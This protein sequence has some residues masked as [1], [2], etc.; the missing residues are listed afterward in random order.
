MVDG[1]SLENCCTATYRGFESLRL[2]FSSLITCRQWK[3]GLYLLGWAAWPFSV[4]PE[5]ARPTAPFMT[6]DK[7]AKQPNV[8][9]IF[10]DDSG[11]ADFSFNGAVGYTTP[12]VD[13]M[14]LQGIRFTNYYSAQPISGASRSALVT[15]CYSNRIGLTGAPMTNSPFGLAEDEETIGELMQANGYSTALVGKWHIGDAEMFLPPHHG[16][17]EW[18]GLPYSNDMW[19]NH[20]TMKF[21]RLPLYDGLEIKQYIDTDEDMSQLTTM[22]TERAVDFIG[23]NARAWKPFFLYFAQAMPHVPLAVSDKF[24]GKSEAGLF[25]DVM[26]ELDWSIGQVRQALEDNGIAD[27]TLIIITS[28]NG[29]WSNYGNH[30]G[31]SGGFREGKSTTFN[32]GLRVPC[33]F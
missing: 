27:N 25:G 9:L 24:K 30:A 16:F 10:L 11:F 14:A 23:R 15:G 29:P 21:S 1:G 26:M 7:N 8:V 2:R 31:S 6:L 18:L 3:A 28:D 17:D 22:Y 20:P 32:G 12:N 5:T 33:I 13:H 4:V 19:P